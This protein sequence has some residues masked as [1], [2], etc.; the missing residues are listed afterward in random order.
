MTR[1][2]SASATG[3]G[4][5]R[6]PAL[7]GLRRRWRALD[8]VQRGLLLLLLLRWAV[9]AAFLLNVLPLAMR[10]GWH[11]HQGGD[12]AEIFE[13]ARSIVI[14]A[15]EESV[16][17]LGQAIVMMPWIALFNAYLYPDIAAPM[18]LFDGFLLGGLS[19]LLVGGLARTLLRDGRTALGAAAVWAVL[20]LL[21]YFGFFWHSHADVLAST[22]VPKVAWLNGLSDGP[23]VFILLI[24]TLLLAR[25]MDRRAIT[26]GR[27][28]AVGL[29]LGLALM[30][31][32]QLAPMA[33]FLLLYVLVAHGWRAFAAALGGALIGYLPQATYNMSAFGLPFTSG[34]VSYGDIPQFDGALRRPLS[35]LLTNL[36]F[37]PVNPLSQV[38][39]FV[40]R[41]PW[42]L[43]PLIAGLAAGAVVLII[44]WRERGWRTVA[45]LLGAPLAYQL[46]IM[47]TDVFREDAI[48]LSM[49]LIPGLII[50][51]VYVALS[52]V[53]RLSQL[54]PS[55]LRGD[56][57]HKE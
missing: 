7:S 12:N 52:I 26:F 9:D 15:P 46:P 50:A 11:L 40:G 4:H 34:Y 35:D 49:P 41:R 39:Y 16:V 57:A 17:G 42:L 2:P 56:A 8:R 29:L 48:R 33:A 27:S 23:T 55:A 18:A 51:A 45:L 44:L 32:L 37:D 54:V 22:T 3:A 24:A 30:W 47:A 6:F 31:R 53:P 36:P 38:A 21:A 25:V 14:G 19:V 10:S 28:L 13:L 43:V 20:P 1:S 5:R